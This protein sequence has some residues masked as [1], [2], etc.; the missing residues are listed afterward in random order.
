MK[1]PRSHVPQPPETAAM[2]ARQSLGLPE[3]EWQRREE[4]SPCFLLQNPS[5]SCFRFEKWP[6]PSQ[7][8]SHE[9]PRQ[10]HFCQW[11][12]TMATA[13]YA[14]EI[15]DFILVLPQKELV[16]APKAALGLFLLVASWFTNST[17]NPQPQTI[18]YLPYRRGWKG[19]DALWKSGGSLWKCWVSFCGGSGE[20]P[21]GSVLRHRCL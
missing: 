13:C 1:R 19:R 6:V 16:F 5:K 9:L 20:G 17:T 3:V 12:L 11:T 7:L 18:T 10:N 21:R 4:S 15:L 2:D 8:P 14:Q